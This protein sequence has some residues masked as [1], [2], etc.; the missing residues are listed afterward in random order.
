M[1]FELLL[2]GTDRFLKLRDTEMEMVWHP[3]QAFRDRS[4]LLSDAA[5][6][7][8]KTSR[9]IRVYTCKNPTVPYGTDLLGWRSSRHFV[10]GYDRIVPPGHFKQGLAREEKST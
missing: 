6:R 1:L 2:N 3:A 7:R 5:N 4:I 9:S 10:P 8:P